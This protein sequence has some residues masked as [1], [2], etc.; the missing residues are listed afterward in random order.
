MRQATIIQ[1]YNY[2]V[3][4]PGEESLLFS[5]KRDSPSEWAQMPKG[6]GRGAAEAEESRSLHYSLQHGAPRGR[7]LCRCTRDTLSYHQL[8]LF[9]VSLVSGEKKTRPFFFGHLRPGLSKSCPIPYFYGV[10]DSNYLETDFTID[11]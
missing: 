2:R 7:A 4:S 8:I 6:G 11:V 1:F 9:K 5:G 3:K 10:G